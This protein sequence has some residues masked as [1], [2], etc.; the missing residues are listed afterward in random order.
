VR[1]SK[2]ARADFD[3]AKIPEARPP[4]GRGAYDFHIRRLLVRKI[5]IRSRGFSIARTPLKRRRI[6][7]GRGASDF[8]AGVYWCAQIETPSRRF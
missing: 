6:A 7:A 8:T 4:S 1:R 2:S 5:E 3:R